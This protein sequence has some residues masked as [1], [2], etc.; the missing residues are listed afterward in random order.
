[1]DAV[2][3]HVFAG[4]FSMG[5]K[6]VFNVNEQL[7]L[8]N[9]GRET[10]EQR[11][12]MEF[13]NVDS[14][15]KWPIRNVAFAFGNPRCTGFSSITCGYGEDAHGPWSA[16]TQDIW[17]FCRYVV[18]A[19]IP[20]AIWESVQQ[21]FTTGRPLLDKLRDEV[22]VPAG[23]RIAHILLNYGSFG[24][25]QQ[26]KRYFFVAY[27]GGNFNIVPPELGAHM[28]TTY[29]AIWDMRDRETHEISRAGMNGSGDYVADCYYPLG[30]YEWHDVPFVPPMGSLNT[31]ARRYPQLMHQWHRDAWTHRS[32]DIPFSLHCITRM[33]WTKPFGTI[34]SSASRFLH[35]DHNRPVTIGEL[36]RVMGWGDV[37]PAGGKPIAQIAKGVVPEAGEWLAQQAKL[38]LDGYWGAEDWES[39]YDS[40][41]GVWAGRETPGAIEKVFNMTQY[42]PKTIGLERF[43]NAAFSRI[44]RSNVDPGTGRLLNPWARDQWYAGVDWSDV[45]A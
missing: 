32:S 2:G 16:P 41:K 14:W 17:D 22:F 28:S 19:E 10:V 38:F 27:R 4:G 23:Y 13:T 9:F 12:G 20:V 29:D 24:S 36:S 7:E 25:S 15:D 5:V 34:H 40:W 39:S 44:S 37:I 30:P 21:A 11:L 35:P 42:Y 31:L 1:M 33:A 45:S 18:R 26:R 8:H 6:R 43:P 3:I